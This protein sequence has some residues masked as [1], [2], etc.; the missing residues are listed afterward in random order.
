MIFEDKAG[1]MLTLA[2]G[3]QRPPSSSPTKATTKLKGTP[4]KS[5]E[6]M[7]VEKLRA[8]RPQPVQS[9]AHEP[10]SWSG[11]WDWD[12]RSWGWGNTWWAQGY[13]YGNSWY[14]G[15]SFSS[16]AWGRGWSDESLVTEASPSGPT[17]FP[18]IRQVLRRPKTSEAELTQAESEADAHAKKNLQE[19]LNQATEFRNMDTMSTESPDKATEFRSLDTMS[20]QQLLGPGRSSSQLLEEEAYVIHLP[21]LALL[22]LIHQTID[23]PCRICRHLPWKRCRRI[24]CICV[25]YRA[26]MS[27]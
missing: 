13:G 5:P 27:V 11:G 21:F 16:E 26:C 19:T 17:S 7:S 15:G 2:R 1:A 23:S 18:E 12:D 6:P 14:A 24:G 8:E 22:Q 25:P 3:S 4:A 9:W 10:S 20:T